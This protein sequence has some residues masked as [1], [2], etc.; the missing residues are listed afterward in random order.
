M[1]KH[2]PEDYLVD[3]IGRGDQLEMTEVELREEIKDALDEYAEARVATLEASL[4]ERLDTTR[5]VAWIKDPNRKPPAL[6]FSAGWLR[7]AADAV[8]VSGVLAENERFREAA[9]IADRLVKWDAK[10]PKGTIHSTVGEYELDSIINSARLIAS[11][12]EPTT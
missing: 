9:G 10:Y 1:S 4:A 3:L 12:K 11:P 6:A 7:E 8:E 5:L 2:T